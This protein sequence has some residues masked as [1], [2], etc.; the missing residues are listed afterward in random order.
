[1]ALTQKARERMR[2]LLR[3]VARV[4]ALL[5]VLSALTAASPAGAYPSCGCTSS[6]GR[7]NLDGSEAN[8]TFIFDTAA[9]DGIAVDAAHIYWANPGSGSPSW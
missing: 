2:P 1:M 6:I 9:S 5:L 3:L 4:A 7:A 8:P